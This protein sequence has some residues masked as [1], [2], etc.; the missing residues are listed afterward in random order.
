MYIGLRGGSSGGNDSLDISIWG[1]QL[2]IAKFPSSYIP[3]VASSVGRNADVLTYSA[4]GIDTFPMTLSA[5]YVQSVDQSSGSG[6]SFILALNEDTT[7]SQD[8]MYFRGQQAPARYEGVVYS[9]T[10]LEV[11]ITGGTTAAGVLRTLTMAVALNDVEM[12][13]D[14]V[15]VA[16]DVSAALPA[17]PTLINIGMN[18][19]S[20]NQAYGNIRNVRIYNKRLTDEQV[21][22]L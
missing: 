4:A 19:I 22:K 15:S 8:E 9:G 18:T 3:T 21:S 20:G 10:S 5:Q 6:I 13:V 17:A 14:G 7:A 1:A 2:E 11:D 16:S 12:Y